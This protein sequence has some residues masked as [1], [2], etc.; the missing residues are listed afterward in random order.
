MSKGSGGRKAAGGIAASAPSVQPTAASAQSVLSAVDALAGT[1]GQFGRFKVWISDVK[2]KT[3]ATDAQLIDM[4]KRGEINLTRADLTSVPE[5]QR[6]VGDSTILHNGA[7]FN[8]V[9]RP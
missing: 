1:P 5:Q 7:T 2:A 3:G 9:G 4:H 6:R 8:F